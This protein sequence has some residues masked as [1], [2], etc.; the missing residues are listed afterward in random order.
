MKYNAKKVTIDGIV[1]DSGHEGDVY[2]DRK[3]ALRAGLITKLQCHTLFVMVVNEIT[4]CRFKPDFVFHEGGQVR[5]WDAKG[6]KKSKKTGKLLPRVDRE[7]GLK[8]K[9]MLALF[10]LKVECV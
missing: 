5:V 3:M 7:F 10:G 8:C 4:I 9:L 2:L 1:F 6:F